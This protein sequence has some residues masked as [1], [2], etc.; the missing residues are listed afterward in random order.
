MGLAA[1]R[2]SRRWRGSAQHWV[3][4]SE[5]VTTAGAVINERLRAFTPD[6]AS[7]PV[8]GSAG[9]RVRLRDP[10]GAVF[11]DEH[12]DSGR[13]LWMQHAEHADIAEVE[14]ACL[15]T[16]PE[17]GEFH[18]GFAAAGEAVAQLDGVEFFS[19]PV[20][21]T[22]TTTWPR[23]SPRAR[24][25]TRS[26]CAPASRCAWTCGCGRAGCHGRSRC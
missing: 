12:R 26:G 17:D 11:R 10:G 6:Q 9:V 15:F 20:V 13:L 7:D 8:D 2:H 4:G 1:V 5:L 14:A 3:T 24:S 18:L 22:R 16:A 23:C 21:A 25:C 19:G